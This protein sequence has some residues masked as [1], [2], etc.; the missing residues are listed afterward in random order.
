MATI[1]AA[2]RTKASGFTLIELMIVVAVV[3]IL[4][5][6]V[7]PEVRNYTVRSKVSEAVLV[8]SAC[9]ASVSEVFQAHN[10]TT[11]ANDWGCGENN[12]TTRYVSRLNTTVDGA[13]VV[14]L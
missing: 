10:V 14:T 13:I 11:G 12:T 9:R 3:A 2:M 6:T 8:M 5:A 1:P 7:L 4:A